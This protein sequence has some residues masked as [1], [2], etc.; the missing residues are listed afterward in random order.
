MTTQVKDL[1]RLILKP[2]RVVRLIGDE[3]DPYRIA[4]PPPIGDTTFE[5]VEFLKEGEGPINGKEMLERAKNF[6][7]QASQ[8]QADVL[9]DNSSQIPVE[10]RGYWLI[11]SGTGWPGPSGDNRVLLM[12][13][14]RNGFWY[15]CF[16]TLH[17][18]FGADYRLVQISA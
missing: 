12:C 16:T 10:W 15:E 2:R 17:D 3:M 1:P 14:D 7:R 5:I 18:N 13:C 4:P 8:H 11:F 6:V 9:L